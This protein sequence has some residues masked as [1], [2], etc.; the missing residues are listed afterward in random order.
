MTR[1]KRSRVNLKKTF[2]QH[3]LNRL[4]VIIHKSE[5]G[6]GYIEKRVSLILS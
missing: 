3:E 1:V 4:N 6:K 5:I 2:F